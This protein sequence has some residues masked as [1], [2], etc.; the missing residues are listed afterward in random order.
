MVSSP[1]DPLW[2]PQRPGLDREGLLAELRVMLDRL[3]PIDERVL[4]AVSGG[5]DSTAMAYL[6][7]EAR[8]DLAPIVGHVRHGLRDDREDAAVAAA[9]A[10]ALTLAFR[11]RRL[12]IEVGREGVEAAARAARYTAL[13][14]LARAAG[15]HFVLVA[16]TADDQAETV[17]LNLVRGG[18]L[19]GLAGMPLSRE[20]GEIRVLRPLL[21]VRRADLRNFVAGEGLAAVADPMNVDAQR[22]RTRARYEALPAL[23]RLAGGPGDV[24]ASLARFADLARDDAET[25]DALALGRAGAIVVVWGPVR[26]VRTDALLALPRALASRLVRLWLASVPGG[27]PVDAETVASVLRLAPGGAQHA[28]GGTWVTC[29]GGWLAARAQRLHPLPSTPLDVPGV[30]RLPQLG[31]VVRADRPWAEASAPAAGTGQERLALGSALAPRR[32]QVREAPTPL[33]PPPP[34]TG[35]S[36]DRWAVIGDVGALVVRGRRP[37]DRLRLAI[38]E[39]RLADV[40]ID[41][42]VP[43]AVRDLIPIVV[44]A[45]DAPVWVPGVAVRAFSSAEPAWAR[46]WL[47]PGRFS[48]SA[49]LRPPDVDGE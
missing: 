31:L 9:H 18:G 30:V 35:P 8:P 13:A 14:Q 24:V 7:V 36:G 2:G 12:H 44:D 21:R 4:L 40:L 27:V 19:A 22:R 41:R 5:P 32:D 33:G 26:A 29:G 25:L 15:A 11:E 45:T 42:G 39:R 10:A 38:G 3:V 20:E 47:A 28:P 1:A 37:G 17:L 43:R 23:A 34:R 6:V 16:H 46:L 48:L 49:T